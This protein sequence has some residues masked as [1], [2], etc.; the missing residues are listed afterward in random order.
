M[1][2]SKGKSYI[3]T[4]EFISRSI[5]NRS[6]DDS[7]WIDMLMSRHF[8]LLKGVLGMAAPE[9]VWNYSYDR[10]ISRWIS[11]NDWW[12]I[13]LIVVDRS[14]GALFN[15]WRRS[16]ESVPPLFKPIDRISSRQP[17]NNPPFAFITFSSFSVIFP[18]CVTVVL[19][20]I[21]KSLDCDWVMYDILKSGRTSD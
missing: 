15:C 5:M 16:A 6:F 2:D 14:S 10:W 21:S 13:L 12:K 9:S 20:Q 19:I 18:L 4:K 17:C 11:M 7:L 8:R 1:P 3:N